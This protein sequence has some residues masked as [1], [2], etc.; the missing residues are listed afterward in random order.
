MSDALFQVK[1]TAALSCIV[2]S[3]RR[4]MQAQGISASG[5][6]DWFA[7]TINNRLLE[8]TEPAAQVEI[9]AGQ[10][11][12]VFARPLRI[13]ITGGKAH[14]ELNQQP[15]EQW[16]AVH[17]E[18]GDVLQLV[19]QPNAARLYLGVSF[20]IDSGTRYNS[21][22]TVAR[23]NAGG[24]AN[25]GK[26]LNYNDTVYGAP[27]DV[28]YQR[29]VD[30][31]RLSDLIRRVYQHGPIRVL[32]GEQVEVFSRLAWRRLLSESYT[33][34][35]QSNR[36]GLRLRGNPV[37]K[38]QFKMRSEPLSFGSMQVPPDGQPIIMMSDRQTLGGYPKLAKV[39]HVDL[40]R[41]A[42]TSIDQQI[43]FSGAD[44]VTARNDW[45]MLD[46]SIQRIFY[47]DS[48]S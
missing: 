36:M 44:A 32:P 41:L 12:A 3:G 28:Q 5:P 43:S 21:R 27:T 2:D 20:S 47:T 24:L 4:G 1:E 38:M 25:D 34:T 23:E 22:C 45:R 33:L 11:R 14:C 7:Y 42:Q 37:Q 46:L 26:A 48:S 9:T 17:V 35:A 8:H 6:M 19:I 29:E 15:I 39:A 13:A 18:K 10:F 16:K 40:P 31:S 30:E